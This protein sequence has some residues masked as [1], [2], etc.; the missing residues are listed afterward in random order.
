MNKFNVPI[1]GFGKYKMNLITQEITNKWDNEVKVRYDRRGQLITN[2]L[3]DQGKQRTVVFSDLVGN[4]FNSLTFETRSDAILPR[5]LVAYHHIFDDTTKSLSL[6]EV[7]RT[8]SGMCEGISVVEVGHI[9][10]KI[11]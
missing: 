8:V 2:I 7:S 1:P 5:V 3:D 10:L 4:T 6:Q 11:H 9:L